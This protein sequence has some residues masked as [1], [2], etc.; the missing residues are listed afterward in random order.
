MIYKNKNCLMCGL[1]YPP[2]SSNQKYCIKCGLINK[3]GREKEY[4]KR[5][6]G[7]NKHRIKGYNQKNY[8]KNKEK[9]LK[10]SKNWRERNKEKHLQQKKEYYQKN[11]DKILKKDKEYNKKLKVKKRKKEYDKKYN[12]ENKDK[13]LEQ[14][15]RYVKD[16]KKKIN[17]RLRERYKTNKNFKILCNLRGSVR[18]M[19]TQ[20]T[21]TGKIMS[22]KEYGIDY[23]KIIEHLKPFPEDLSNY[24]IHHIKPLFTFNFVNKGGSTSLKEVQKAFAPQNHKLVTIEEHKEIHRKLNH[25]SLKC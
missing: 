24:H 11:R 15:K 5:W 19:F 17:S 10:I 7:K 3:K 6:W 20:Y 18:F 8:K 14:S 23:K 21:K 12:I 2:N 1:E 22:S 4:N 16:N 25:N 13:I 9:N